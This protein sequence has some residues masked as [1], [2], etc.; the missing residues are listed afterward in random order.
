MHEAAEQTVVLSRRRAHV[1]GN[2]DGDDERVHGDDTRHDHG[3]EGLAAVS[4]R[5]CNHHEMLAFMIKSGLKVPTPEMPM[6]DLAVPYAAPTPGVRVSG[7]WWAAAS[8][9]RATYIRRS[10]GGAVSA[11]LARRRSSESAYCE[12][13][14]ALGAVSL[15]RGSWR[16]RELGARRTMPKKG[17]NLGVRSDSMAMQAVRERCRGRRR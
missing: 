1:A 3:D 13:N 6:P 12:G 4:P 5:R 10:S 11:R 15:H 16:W 8:S 7:C 2:E 17:A 14:T 9:S